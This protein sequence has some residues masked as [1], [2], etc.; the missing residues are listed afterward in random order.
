M[1]ENAACS[2]DLIC[3]AL[4]AD[5]A[6]DDRIVYGQRSGP[7]VANLASCTCCSSH[8][9][10]LTHKPESGFQNS[11]SSHTLLARMTI[12]RFNNRRIPREAAALINP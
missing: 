10:I 7:Y 9:A 11:D 6:N 4:F 2:G 3:P 12:R 1:L 8:A 5:L